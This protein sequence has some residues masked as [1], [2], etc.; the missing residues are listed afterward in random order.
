MDA[1]A[2]RGSGLWVVKIRLRRLDVKNERAEAGREGRT[3]LTRPNSQAR[4]G[5]GKTH[6]PCSVE[7][8]LDWQPHWLMSSPVC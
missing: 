4:T 6:F 8:K 3:R 2:E 1:V 7:Y 5:T